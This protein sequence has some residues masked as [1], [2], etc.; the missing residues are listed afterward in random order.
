MTRTRLLAVDGFTM[1][2][3]IMLLTAISGLALAGWSAA[4]G[5]VAG[6]QRDNDAKRAYS[7]AES[8][9]AE[10][11]QKLAGDNEY[12]LKCVPDPIAGQ[13]V[14]PVNQQWNPGDPERQWRVMP[15]DPQASYTIE[16]LPAN[17]YARCEDNVAESMLGP[18]GIQIRTT[19][20]V[21]PRGRE[22]K[23]SIVSSLRRR[24][25]L[26]FIYF[27]EYETS[28]PSQL[29]IR[30]PGEVK[31]CAPSIT[32][33]PDDLATWGAT[34]TTCER[35]VRPTEGST[36]SRDTVRY[37]G[38]YRAP[39]GGEDDWQTASTLSSPPGPI[40][41]TAIQ[42]ADGDKIKGPFHTEDTMMLCGQPDF[43]RNRAGALTEP[44]D[45]IEYWAYRIT[46]G[47]AS[48]SRPDI[49]NNTAVT[50]SAMELLDLPETNTELETI[51]GPAYTFT[52][53]TRL[54]FSGSTFKVNDGAFQPLPPKG[55]IYV[56]NNPTSPCPAHN[57]LTPNVVAPTCGDAY[58][59][60]TYSKSVT[61]AA[62]R[63]IVLAGDFKTDLDSAALGGLI[64]QNVRIGHSMNGSSTRTNTCPEG[65]VNA[66]TGN[67]QV[68]A[69]IAAIQHVFTVDNYQCGAQLGTLQVTGAIAQKYRGPVGTS[70]SSGTGYIK[71]YIY[72]N[73]FKFR[74]PP[75][76]TAP[77]NSSWRVTRTTEQ[78]P[79]T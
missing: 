10:Y 11:Q 13:P 12:W 6:A 48:T 54:E 51:A 33:A 43:G 37:P 72:D 39:G 27:T 14:V 42:F 29:K 46:S 35:W 40:G 15:G 20:K 49:G 67:R 45:R 62:E 5:D 74:S 3:V 38:S 70:G 77:K 34:K 71:E 23:R 21:G 9:L 75:H 73:R 19:G 4:G 76:F 25:F 28:D 56:R 69:A 22:V 1:L 47:C 78:S 24:G 50:G 16:L 60:G 57:P 68:H 52:G 8:G 63:D 32:C 2:P 58:V 26:D 31:R 7:A 59:K 41:C 79:A 30:Y 61:I 44:V 18:S 64:G 53:T 17:G 55:V 65:T 36:G 66:T